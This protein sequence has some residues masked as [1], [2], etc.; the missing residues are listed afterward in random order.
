[1]EI[2]ESLDHI[3]HRLRCRRRQMP[4]LRMQT[5][6]KAHKMPDFDPDTPTR[7]YIAEA[8]LNGIN[9]DIPAEPRRTREEAEEDAADW[10]FW[11]TDAERAKAKTWVVPCSFG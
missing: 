4:M 3:P 9:W 1:M 5:P 6:M 10:L 8:T 11:L 7:F 2:V